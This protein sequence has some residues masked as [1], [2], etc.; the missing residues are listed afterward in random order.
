MIHY[1]TTNGIGNAWVANE[2]SRLE[3]GGVP[4]VL[5]ALRKPEALFHGSDWA[6]RLN[7]RTRSIYP[8][9]GPALL[10]SLLLAPLLFRGRFVAALLNALFGRRE[11][12][13]ARIGGIAHLAV[14]CHWARRMRAAP[15]PVT[16]IHSQ[17]IHS[18]G[19]VAMYLGWLLD[20]PFSFTGHATDLFRDRCALLDKIERADFIVCISEFHRDFYL[21][22]GARPEQC[23]I[24]YCGI[25]P[26][27]FHPRAAAAV[28]ADRPYR[29]LASGRLVEK[30]GFALLVDA[31]RL[32]ADRGL[33]FECVIGGSGP[34]EASLRAQV[35]RLGLADRVSVTGQALQ[36]ERIIDF[37]HGGDVYV[38][39]C[40]WAADGDVDGLP[41]MLMEAMAC[42]LPAVSTRLVGIPDLIRDDVT[43]VLVPPED[44]VALADAIANLMGDPARSKRL[45]DAGLRWV[46]ER[47]DLSSCLEPLIDRYRQRLGLAGAAPT[48]LPLSAPEASRA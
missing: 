31:C 26:A 32:L 9:P 5:H 12:S 21:K 34:L 13:R 30:K 23:V 17:W 38:L 22:H 24:A 44:T 14:A 2:L 37:M 4:F 10:L 45:A 42:G 41:Q 6:V 25:D 27:V 16:H 19:T 48:T 29:I 8:L 11:H 46:H 35:E 40:V 43:G 7:Q 36:Q 1:I 39:P 28:A 47:F 3:A 20:K 33:R 18:C 15:E